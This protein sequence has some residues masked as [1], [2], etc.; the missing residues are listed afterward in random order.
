MYGMVGFSVGYILY[1]LYNLLLIEHAIVCAQYIQIITDI[2]ID[3]MHVY[4][5]HCLAVSMLYLFYL[6]VCII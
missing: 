2:Y 5:P 3:N 4:S 1:F 6:L